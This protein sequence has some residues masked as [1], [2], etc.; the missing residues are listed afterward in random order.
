MVR[1]NIACGRPIPQQRA[2]RRLEDEA[3]LVH[4][5][6]GGTDRFHPELER[7]AAKRMNARTTEL[8]SSHVA[9]LSQP[10]R[11]LDV[12]RDAANRSRPPGPGRAVQA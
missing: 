11:V 3:E 2:G 10:D 4:R 9:M 1:P 5:G 6:R 7:F 12:I 8:Q